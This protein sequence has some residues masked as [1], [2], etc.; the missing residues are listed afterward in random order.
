MEILLNKGE[1]TVYVQGIDMEF[2]VSTTGIVVGASDELIVES[3]Y[4]EPGMV[5]LKVLPRNGKPTKITNNVKVAMVIPTEQVYVKTVEEVIEEV[6]DECEDAASP[7]VEDEEADLPEDCSFP[8]DD[9]DV[10][11]SAPAAGKKVMQKRVGRP[12]G[13]RK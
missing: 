12:K 9:S 6:I 11:A 3:K 1:S 7:A 10:D 5:S 2:E 8:G 13:T 4:V